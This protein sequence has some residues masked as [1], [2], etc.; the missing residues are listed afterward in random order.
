MKGATEDIHPS[1]HTG[2]WGKRDDAFKILPIGHYC[3]AFNARPRLRQTAFLIDLLIDVAASSHPCP[4]AVPTL[5]HPASPY[6]L[7]PCRLLVTFW[8]KRRRTTQMAAVDKRIE[9]IEQK[10]QWR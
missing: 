2:Y 9:G 3:L 1:T 6:P 10:V 4:T 8:G 7:P 5:P